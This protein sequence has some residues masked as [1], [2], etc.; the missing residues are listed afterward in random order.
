M[1]PDIHKR[2]LGYYF[3]FL[4]IILA[5]F[6]TGPW[7]LKSGMQVRL[8]GWDLLVLWFIGLIAA[9]L[10]KQSGFPDLVRDGMNPSR[11]IIIPL[12]IGA[13]FGLL[14]ILVFEVFSKHPPYDGLPPFLQPFPYSL[15]LYAS[16]AM[17]VEI[18]HRLIP[19]TLVML[20][21]TRFAGKYRGRIFWMAAILTS[22][23]EPLQQMPSDPPWLIVYSLGS[24]IAFNLL[25][26]IYYKHAGWFA[27]VFIRL[28]HYLL[29]HILLGIYVQ[30]YLL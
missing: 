4:L 5:A 22:L 6:F 14:D 21:A 3:L 25:Q 12:L 20:L 18:L 28:G 16:G 7:L 30:Y 1:N 10:Q 24:G 26:V 29:W 2:S 19:M 27:S 8:I 9:L 23:W 11:R 13:V 15:L 17:H